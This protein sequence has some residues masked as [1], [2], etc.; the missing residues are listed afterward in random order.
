VTVLFVNVADCFVN[1][2]LTN[3]FAWELILIASGSCKRYSVM[4]VINILFSPLS[5]VFNEA[6]KVMAFW[7][8]N[9][10]VFV[11][12]YRAFTVKFELT[13][14]FVHQHESHI[15]VVNVQN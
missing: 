1:S 13:S 15:L 7:H 9:S 5:E 10:T 14:N 11:V 4:H 12:I 6:V 2:I 8:F 3:I